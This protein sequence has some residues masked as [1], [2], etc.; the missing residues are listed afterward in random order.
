MILG[1]SGP[2]YRNSRVSKTWRSDG[3]LDRV[4]ILSLPAFLIILRKPV[5]LTL[6]REGTNVVV[7][8]QLSGMTN[9]V[10]EKDF[11][12]SEAATAMAHAARL[13]KSMYDHAV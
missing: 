5:I 9:F 1:I 11:L 10:G 13:R 7:T 8:A 6:P 12:L 3:S 4:K 2:S